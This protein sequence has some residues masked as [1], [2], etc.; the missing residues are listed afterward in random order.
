MRTQSNDIQKIR[1]KAQIQTSNLLNLSI[2]STLLVCPIFSF[3]ALAGT[4]PLDLITLDSPQPHLIQ[5]LPLSH[6][7]I[8]V[9]SETRYQVSASALEESTAA[10]QLMLPD[11]TKLI[12]HKKLA[13]S[14]PSGALI[15]QGEISGVKK[16]PG[17]NRIIV[18]K[19]D[20]H[21]SATINFDGKLFKLM[22]SGPN[23][24]ILQE[25]DQTKVPDEHNQPMPPMKSGTKQQAVLARPM[26]NTVQA[27]G[28]SVI[29]VMVGYTS[30]A[31]NQNPGMQALIELAVAETNQG[32][33]DS[34][35]NAQVELAHS[36]E[37]NY[38]ESGDHGTDL[39][40]F[41][42]PNDGYM[43]DVFA[44]RD[45]YSADVA[46]I[47]IG[48]A[49]AC[50]RARAIGATEDTAFMVIKDSCA[51]GYYSFGHELG[52]LMSARHNPEKDD[53]TIPYAFGHGFL[54]SSGGW[55]SIM[56]YNDS[57]CCS[58]QNFWSDPTQS[59]QGI[60]RGTTQTHDNARV[61]NLTA[62]TVAEFRSD[63]GGSN[64]PPIA[65][66]STSINDLTVYFIDASSDQDGNIV[67]YLWDF[68][69]G[70]Q[71]SLA[72][73]DHTYGATGTYT[74]KLTVIDDR[75]A[76]NTSSLQV[77]VI[78]SGVNQVPTASFIFNTQGREVNFIDQSLDNDGQ[79]VSWSWEFG[80]GTQSSVQAPK[81][82]YQAVGSYWVELTVTDDAG[83]TD[84]L[85]LLI[86]VSSEALLAAAD[87]ETDLGS[88]S[89]SPA[90]DWDWSR[91]SGATASSSTGP[92]SG[93]GGQ[94]YYLYLE[95]SNNK[96][97]Y[98]AGE[99]AMIE[100]GEFSVKSSRLSFDY[101]M[102][103]ADIGTL[104]IDVN[105]NGTWFNDVWQISGQQHTS[106]VAGFTPV[107]VDLSVYSG[108][109]QVRVRATAVGGWKGDIAI[110]HL[111]L[112]G[113][114]VTADNQAPVFSVDTIALVDASIDT[115]Y[116]Q[117]ITSFASDP[118]DDSMNFA[119][120]SGSTWLQVSATGEISGVPV[121]ADLGLSSALVRVT[122]SQG[123]SSE[124]TVEI[125]V[126]ESQALE[127]LSAIDFEAG[128]VN[129][130]SNGSGASHLWEAEVGTTS[131][132]STGPDSGAF[133][134]G[135]Y[136]YVE[137]SKDYAY[138]AGDTAYLESPLISGSQRQLSFYYHMYGTE[139]GS[140]SVDVFHQGSWELNLFRISGQ[141]HS[142]TSDEFTQQLV[143]LSSLSGD[144]RVRF[145][146][147]A[148]GGWK[149]DIA[150]DDIQVEGQP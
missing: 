66:F 71:S 108:K 62:A 44:L 118:D 26:S 121:L 104:S 16:V 1:D 132:N 142:A 56:S 32:F 144:I 5:K 73:P 41:H 15:W 116:S 55:R 134:T 69:D 124:A 21:L 22:P 83:A 54:Y 84:T 78:D 35:V 2:I 127:L 65:D 43:D 111:H 60:V 9:K 53:K 119:K 10:L 126:V 28:T 106:A 115:S 77:A 128:I 52:H 131:S 112:F 38:A 72:S 40:R 145:S 18:V 76:S 105:D 3:T 29:R 89:H 51:T 74:A 148:A 46:A 91:L 7:D 135:Q 75:G 34:G 110:D 64:V 137:T 12:A 36:Y 113:T 140:L 87:F 138:G 42:T 30:E 24:V 141:Q 130:W 114:V 17:D 99:Q 14:T 13:Y 149:G 82:V 86:E 146:V 19:S 92:D 20:S 143:D 85:Q 61:L 11:G 67:S 27:S 57:S 103:G 45:Q 100:S 120:V 8:E 33:S 4:E 122:D 117:S 49:S 68:G 136:A 109:L 70:N 79:V 95:T 150:I 80:D 147:E 90:N 101:H 107:N 47:L 50:G 23:E 81:H 133:T 88:W 123:A 96:G 139:I 31:L 98:T 6:V 37:L 102:Y 59:F 25:I 58:R 48:D 129:G 97:A 125:N 94:G 93:A 63:S 39:D